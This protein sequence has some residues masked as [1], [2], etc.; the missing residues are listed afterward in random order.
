MNIN[1][2]FEGNELLNCLLLSDSKA[3][4]MKEIPGNRSLYSILTDIV[5]E[6]ANFDSNSAV[7]TKNVPYLTKIIYVSKEPSKYK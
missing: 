4:V 5:P 3:I 6:I 7:K 1:P 2:L